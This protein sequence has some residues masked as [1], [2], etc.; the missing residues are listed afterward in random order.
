MA[1]SCSIILCSLQKQLV[2]ITPVLL[3]G[4]GGHWTNQEFG[5]KLTT[6]LSYLHEKLALAPSLAHPLDEMLQDRCIPNRG[7]GKEKQFCCPG[8]A[9]GGRGRL[10]RVTPTCSLSSWHGI[11]LCS[12]GE[13][14]LHTA[15]NIQHTNQLQ[16]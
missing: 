7:P 1:S 2:F 14:H 13:K 16:V 12:G 11:G 8:F 9:V 10:V 3:H 4:R 15:I 6:I 5:S